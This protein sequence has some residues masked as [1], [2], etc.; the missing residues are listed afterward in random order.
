MATPD[1][2]NTSA[3]VSAVVSLLSTLCRGSPTI[4]AELLR[5]DLSHAIESALQGDERFV[6]LL[7]THLLLVM[8]KLNM[9]IRFDRS[10]S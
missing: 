6:H 4:S 5:M 10:G 9:Q 1:S 8:L 3:G 2:K 7:Y